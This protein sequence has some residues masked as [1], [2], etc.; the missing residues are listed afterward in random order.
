MIAEACAASF[1]IACLIAAA[2]IATR[3]KG[4]VSVE[5]TIE[6]GNAVLVVR[7]HRDVR[8]IE[9]TAAGDAGSEVRLVRA[10]MRRGS[11]ARFSFPASQTPARVVVVENDSGTHQ[12]E[13]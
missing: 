3:P 7:A 12:L 8:R 5:K 2:Y 1:I 11:E 13:V 4:P 10:G 6:G 9:V